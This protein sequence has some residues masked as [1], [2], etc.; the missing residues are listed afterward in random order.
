MS[1]MEK[2]NA[3][4]KDHT[5]NDLT[6]NEAWGMVKLVKMI[7]ENADRNLEKELKKARG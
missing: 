1:T 2:L 6:E 4:Y 3:I 7:Y 5:G